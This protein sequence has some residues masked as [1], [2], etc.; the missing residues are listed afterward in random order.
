MRDIT[1]RKRAEADREKLVTLVETSTDFIGMCDLEGVPFF[2]NRAGLEMVGLDDI[3]VARKVP[4]ASFFF[5]EDQSRIVEEFFPSVF[6]T[7]AR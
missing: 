3:E 6:G 2:V 7:R 5:P 4:V 1:E